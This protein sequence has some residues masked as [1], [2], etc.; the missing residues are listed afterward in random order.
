[1]NWGGLWELQQFQSDEQ[2][3]L[4]GWSMV[5]RMLDSGLLNFAN[6]VSYLDNDDI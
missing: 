4:I 2:T 3:D 1:M 6:E 5:R